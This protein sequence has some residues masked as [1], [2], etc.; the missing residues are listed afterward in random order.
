MKYTT[1]ERTSPLINSSQLNNT[2]RNAPLPVFNIKGKRGSAS[3]TIGNIFERVRSGNEHCG[4]CGGFKSA[5]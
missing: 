5:F 1:V 2:G 3:I 4:N